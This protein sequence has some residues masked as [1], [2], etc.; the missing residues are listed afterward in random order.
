MGK[1]APD[2]LLRIVDRFDLSRKV[3]LSGDYRESGESGEN[4][5]ESGTVTLFPSDVTRRGNAAFQI[6]DWRLQIGGRARPRMVSL[7]ETMMTADGL[8]PTAYGPD[9]NRIR[10]AEGAANG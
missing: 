1:P 2:A 5:G 7:V 4:Q 3:F 6:A 8:R 9:E 10:M